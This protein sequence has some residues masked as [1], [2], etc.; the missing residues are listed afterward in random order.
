MFCISGAVTRASAC[1]TG[2]LNFY[3]SSGNIRAMKNMRVQDVVRRSDLSKLSKPS[4]AKAAFRDIGSAARKTSRLFGAKIPFLIGFAIILVG[5]VF[6]ARAMVEIVSYRQTVEVMGTQM[7]SGVAISVSKETAMIQNVVVLS[8][9]TTTT[10]SSVVTSSAPAETTWGLLPKVEVPFS[11]TTTKT[12]QSDEKNTSTSKK[13]STQPKSTSTPAIAAVPAPAVITAR[14]FLDATTLSFYERLDGP[15]EIT[16]TTFTG[17]RSKVVWNLDNP[18]VGGNGSIPLFSVSFSCKPPPNMPSSDAAD[19]S[20][21]F[22]PRTSYI[23]TIGLAPTSG[24]D[25]RTQPKEFSFTTD[26]GQ[27]IITLPP[28]MNNVLQDSISNGGLVFNN[29]DMNPITITGLNFDVSYRALSTASPLVLRVMD[30]PSTDY[31]LENLAGDSSVPPKYSGE[32]ITIPFSFTIAPN[33]QKMLPI[34][35]LG[36]NRM[37]IPGIDPTINIRIRTV[38]TDRND[39]KMVLKADRISWS[40]AVPAV[41]TN[42]S[43]NLCFP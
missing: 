20:P 21:A 29:E 40:C 2:R 11:T 22:D 3:K 10:T 5:G 42:P 31:H 24:S 16:L 27:L 13:T 35:I 25:R 15:Y 32:N 33:T 26:P 14:T 28:A 6:V 17:T 9:S 23:C 1:F 37:N 18:S 43:G 34:K 36:A 7:R 8:A 38:M 41:G 12:A 30:D 4:G 19:Q 39:S